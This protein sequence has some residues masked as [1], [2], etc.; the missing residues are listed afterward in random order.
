MQFKTKESQY[1]WVAVGQRH[2]W[3][4][5]DA[6]PCATLPH[7]LIYAQVRFPREVPGSLWN[8]RTNSHSM[9]QRL[10][11]VIKSCALKP[12]LQAVKLLAGGGLIIMPWIYAQL[13]TPLMLENKRWVISYMRS[14][15]VEFCFQCSWISSLNAS[16]GLNIIS[17]MLS[18][19]CVQKT[20]VLL[21]NINQV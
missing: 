17:A 5:S 6:D 14:Y 13:L 19:T 4:A 7:K 1:N 20:H 16:C 15:L 2:P 9:L 10:P 21:Q 12:C 3:W 8:W 18:T 11:T